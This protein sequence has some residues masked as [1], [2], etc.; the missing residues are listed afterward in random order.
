MH[1]VGEQ[2]C[3]M[4]RVHPVSLLQRGD[5]FALLNLA[6]PPQVAQAALIQPMARDCLVIQAT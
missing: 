3:L 6:Q 5:E 1:E 4:L 2:Y